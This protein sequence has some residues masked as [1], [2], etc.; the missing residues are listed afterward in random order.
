MQDVVIPNLL[1]VA[2]DLVR[3]ECGDVSP[4]SKR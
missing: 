1:S 3:K 4:L 2:F